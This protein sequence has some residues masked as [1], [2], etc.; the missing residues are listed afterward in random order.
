MRSQIKRDESAASTELGYIFT[1]ML[2]VLL[3]SMFSVWSFG[4]E[5]A[6]R[7]RWNQNAIETNLAD[8]TSAV[9]RADQASHAG[10]SIQYAEVVKWRFTEAD[11]T[12][13]RLT[14]SD[15]GLVLVH[16]EYELNREVS[17][18]AT[19]AGNY[20]GSISLS[21]LSEIWI[22]HQDGNT[23]IATNRPSF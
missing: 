9:E 2:G 12:L 6:T 1:F 17:I 19:G 4:I 22:I 5:T 23:S 18:S 15:E 20:S 7:E 11:E 3:L 13:F 16:D 10:D 8:I 21:G 14:L